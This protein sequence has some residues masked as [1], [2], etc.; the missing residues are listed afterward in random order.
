MKTN[1]NTVCCDLGVI[2]NARLWKMWR[3]EG[4]IS[5]GNELR[6]YQLTTLVTLAARAKQ[7]E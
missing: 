2:M 1:K 6:R 5:Q 7:D 3:K 4:K